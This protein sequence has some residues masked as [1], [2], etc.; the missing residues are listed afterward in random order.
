[1]NEFER[2][3]VR[4]RNNTNLDN[5]VGLQLEKQQTARDDSM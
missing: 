4:F 2:E 3:N 5:K 1:M